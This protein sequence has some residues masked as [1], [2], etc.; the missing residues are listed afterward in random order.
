MSQGTIISLSLSVSL[1]A[2]TKL[3][4]N[5]VSR[6]ENLNWI[7]ENLQKSL[8]FSSLPLFSLLHLGYKFKLFLDARKTRTKTLCQ[9]FYFIRL[10]LFAMRA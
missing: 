9:T 3:H 2:E 1:Q 7:E 10:E 4:P 5:R 8:P 6:L